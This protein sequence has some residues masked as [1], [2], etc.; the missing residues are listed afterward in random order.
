MDYLDLPSCCY[1]YRYDKYEDGRR[2]HDDEWYDEME[3]RLY[4]YN[5]DKE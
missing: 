2:V 1:D 5:R 3:D 4:E